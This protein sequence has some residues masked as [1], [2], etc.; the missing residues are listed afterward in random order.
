MTGQGRGPAY[1]H[2]SSPAY[3]QLAEMQSREDYRSLVE[4]TGALVIRYK[5]SGRFAP[6]ITELSKYDTRYEDGGEI[7]VDHEQ[8]DMYDIVNYTH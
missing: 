5:C 2:Q 6:V 3:L 4:S 8:Q 7:S 1:T